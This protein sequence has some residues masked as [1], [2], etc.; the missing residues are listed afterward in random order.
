[1]FTSNPFSE[2]TQLSEFISPAIMQWY[3]IL[4]V[5]MVIGG[6]I[7]DMVHKKSAQ[8]FF[9]NAKKAQKNAKREVSTGEKASLAVSTLTSEVLTSSEFCNTRRRISL[10]L[11]PL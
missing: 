3:V 5:I 2:L 1:M 7:L 4:M 9:E 10:L 8:Y 6:T 11:P